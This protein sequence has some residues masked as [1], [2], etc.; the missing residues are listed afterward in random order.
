MV[1]KLK[2]ETITL[3]CP[4]PHG[5][6]RVL[7][8]NL[9]ILLHVAIFAIPVF[10]SLQL[11]KPE[12]KREVSVDLV[13]I[14]APNIKGESE[15]AELVKRTEEVKKTQE[16]IVK[17]EPLEKL[18]PAEQKLVKKDL[19]PIKLNKEQPAKTPEKQV[20]KKQETTN[21]NGNS[22]STVIQTLSE[23]DYIRTVAPIYPRRAVEMGFQG[24]VVIKALI[25]NSGKAEKVMVSRSSGYESLDDSA[26]AAV[27]KWYFKPKFLSNNFRKT[28]VNIPVRFVLK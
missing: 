19:P 9:S 4:I 13:S 5:Q 23:Q 12:F 11:S 20:T 24:K 17:K 22:I 16:V 25:N 1:T 8:A 6:K 15:K 26:L 3:R 18:R 21:N 2:N 14:A 27:E 10:I 28:W 7:S